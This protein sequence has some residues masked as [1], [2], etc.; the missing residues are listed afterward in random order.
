M[1]ERADT[2]CCALRNRE[3]QRRAEVERWQQEA[4]DMR[5]RCSLAE[6][7]LLRRSGTEFAQMHE[8]QNELK[9]LQ[10][11]L[12]ANTPH[13]YV[14]SGAMAASSSSSRAVASSPVPL[15]TTRG[16][17]SSSRITFIRAQAIAWL[18]LYF[19]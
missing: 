17:A 15:T 19:F 3:E 4:D 12:V 13:L 10:A 11:E 6:R 9:K 1:G 8:L 18:Q 2:D 5:A 7:E 14:A 16:I